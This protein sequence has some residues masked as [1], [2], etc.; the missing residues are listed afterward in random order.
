MAPARPTRP[1]AR[2][3]SR[4]EPSGL[5]LPPNPVSIP[6]VAA[7]SSSPSTENSNT[8]HATSSSSSPQTLAAT[9][10]PRPFTRAVARSLA[11]TNL[12][13]PPEGPNS[14]AASSS[15]TT[16]TPVSGSPRT[17]MPASSALQSTAAH[18]PKLSDDPRVPSPACAQSS[19]NTPPSPPSK[20]AR[21][22]ASSRGTTRR[23]S[24]TRLQAHP[25]ELDKSMT[26]SS[27]SI[28]TPTSTKR[29]R[30]ATDGLLWRGV[31]SDSEVGVSDS[32]VNQAAQS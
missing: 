1:L 31:L 25:A 32:K 10:S 7:S 21:A 19:R 20:N 23:F 18:A 11:H 2:S 26:S 8:T 12:P 16:L 27:S 30:T 17:R 3:S 6:H 15:P 4:K 28:E 14:A 5:A 13:T 22:S 9:T 24:Q 29:A